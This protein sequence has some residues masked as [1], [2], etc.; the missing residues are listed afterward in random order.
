MTKTMTKN[1]LSVFL[2]EFVLFQNNWLVNI[3]LTVPNSDISFHEYRFSQ[4][5]KLLV[6]MIISVKSQLLRFCLT[7]AY[8]GIQVL[9][10]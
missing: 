9:V 6:Y 7:L 5:D 8:G 10:V 4:Q 2:D 1:L 3:S